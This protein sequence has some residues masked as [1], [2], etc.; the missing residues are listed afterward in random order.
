M[1]PYTPLYR[2]M[3]SR[4]HLT[5]SVTVYFLSAYSCRRRGTVTS[6]RSRLIA[7]LGAAAA[8][9]DLSWHA[10]A[11]AHVASAAMIERGVMRRRYRAEA[12]RA[13][14]H[15]LVANGLRRLPPARLFVRL[16]H[17]GGSPPHLPRSMNRYY[18]L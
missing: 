9:V 15:P 6:R 18:E 11:T 12:R 2:S 3:R 5:T 1:A 4:C 14:S 17:D 7:A 8:A 10:A 16:A 13:A